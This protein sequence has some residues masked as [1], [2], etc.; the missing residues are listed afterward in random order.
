MKILHVAPSF[1][2]ATLWGGPIFSTKAI[3]D[4]T[5]RA[6]GFEVEVLTTDAL[7]PGT[8]EAIPLENR[9]IRAEAGYPVTYFPR[10]MR[11]SMS[12][13]MLRALPGA[14][15]AA[16]IVHIT[17]TYSF[18]V[19]P[20]LGL[21]R[22]LGCPVVWSPRGAIQ[23]S[24]EWTQAPNKAAKRWFERIAHAIAP[25]RMAVHVTAPSEAA[26]TAARLPGVA[27][28]IVPNS[29][30][31]PRSAELQPRAWRPGGR[32]RLAF[33]SRI[34]P[35][36]GIELLLEAMAD[37][38]DTFDLAIYGQ[39]SDGYVAGLA[40]MAQELGVDER[41]EFC[42]HVEGEAK[43]AAFNRCDLFVLPTYSENFGIVVAEALAHGVPVVTTTATPWDGLGP[44]GSGAI[45]EP[46]V[47]ALKGALLD[48]AVADLAAMGRKGREWM[49]AEFSPDAVDRQ[50]LNLYRELHRAI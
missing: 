10:Q 5:A 18:P 49:I 46:C 17:S 16:D 21:A 20:A 12:L 47:D 41:V 39:G 30:E 2:P 22:L 36:K 28:R 9:T 44:G 19:L 25:R 8:R 3:C 43:L 35:K 26:A 4:G 32:L 15:R 33:L 50:M 1:Y 24:A 6:D 48:L 45:V 29:V 14:I 40:R 13:P 37:L 11:N 42:G 38:P 7:G 27:I 23:A 34:H 31:I